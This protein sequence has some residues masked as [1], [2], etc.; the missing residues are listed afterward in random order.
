MGGGGVRDGESGG[1]SPRRRI[2]K[3]ECLRDW[4]CGSVEVRA[5]L[6]IGGEEV[7]D[8]S[9]VGIVEKGCDSSAELV[10]TSFEDPG[11]ASSGFAIRNPPRDCERLRSFSI[12]WAWQ[13]VLWPNDSP[14]PWAIS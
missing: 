10:G 1:A 4:D 12:P 3:I 14:E 9:V 5:S 8:V 7:V 2:L 13:Y 11:E 6:E